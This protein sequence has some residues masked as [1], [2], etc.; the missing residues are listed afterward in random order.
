MARIHDLERSGDW[1]QMWQ[2][3]ERE[4]EAALKTDQP[5]VA[6]L[7]LFAASR[8]YQMDHRY[9]QSLHAALRSRALAIQAGDWRTAALAAFAV[10]FTYYVTE[11]RDLMREAGEQML[12]YASR[13]TQRRMEML[14]L[15][16]AILWQL[17]ERQQAVRHYRMALEEALDAE[18]PSRVAGIRE[19][20]GL[21]LLDMGQLEQ[22]EAQLIEAYR[23]R[24]LFDRKQI[25]WSYY[26]LA[27][28]RLGQG[29]AG[30]SLRLLEA[31]L[32]APSPGLRPSWLYYYRARALAALGRRDEMLKDLR[33]AIELSRQ[34]RL[35]LPFGDAFRISAEGKLQEIY[36]WYAEESA[37][38]FFRSGEPAHAV[39]SFL[40][41]EENRAHSLR[42]RLWADDSWREQLPTAYWRTLE[43]LRK[44]E[45]AALARPEL[46]TADSLRRL[47]ARLAEM[48]S[49]SGVAVAPC[50]EGRPALHAIQ[51]RLA[52]SELLLSFLLGQERSLLWA[53][54]RKRLRLFSLPSKAALTAA[55]GAF[56]S[57]VEKDGA[58]SWSR[59]AELW[60]MLF[61]QLEEA[62]SRRD[63]II[64]PDEVLFELPYAA[65][66]VAGARG[67]DR[68]LV[69]RL[70]LRLAP[71][72]L[73]MITPSA[74]DAAGFAAIADPITNRADTRWRGSGVLS[75]LFARR[76]ASQL[77]LPRLAS[78]EGEV[79]LAAQ[80]FGQRPALVLTGTEIT[81]EAVRGMLKKR[82]EVL[83][84]ATHFYEST[85]SVPSPVV[86][87][88]LD[89]KGI[90]NALSE[91]E[92]KLL[93]PAP[94][95]VTLSGCGSGLGSLLPGT[96]LRSL[97]RA[98]LMAGSEAVLASL[99][100]TS[101]STGMFFAAYYGALARRRTGD[102]IRDA[103]RALREAQRLA[104]AAGGWQA[105]PWH[106]AAYFLMGGI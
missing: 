22:A 52:E 27:R 106:W 74:L 43:E 41:T 66:P 86:S 58:A 69:E 49:Q 57:A 39:E 63:W 5:A 50:G 103:A 24:V 97:T 51:A 2:L 10:A 82:P 104:I 77:E 12:D 35:H 40:S 6:A 67:R 32:H 73:F 75:R 45:L 94:P 18:E 87:L 100:P 102:R 95:L 60:R 61:G 31:S 89:S 83:H 44:A 20:L 59:G 96:G 53:L 33:R 26:S 13:G 71:S 78:S 81:P 47:R 36:A 14:S 65:L 34:L 3:G 16:G 62:D 54:D 29:R 79:R 7:F 98:W 56:R 93:Q 99:W 84:L 90:M 9:G 17:G 88:G 48:E 30:E 68:F 70:S 76:A 85:P 19:Q 1:R 15:M 8:G 46:P 91:S 55:V 42:A 28:L 23:Q 64:V 11:N 37:A 101:D 92:I 38:E 4:A 25:G 105:E 80:Q 21:R 72:A